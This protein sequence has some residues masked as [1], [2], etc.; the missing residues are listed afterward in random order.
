MMLASPRGA[1]E[2]RAAAAAP[3][4]LLVVEEIPI[5]LDIGNA[6]TYYLPKLASLL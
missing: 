4:W 3:L 6:N 5:F 2:C 1:V